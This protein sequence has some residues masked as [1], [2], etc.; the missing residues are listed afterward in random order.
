MNWFFSCIDH[1]IPLAL[2]PHGGAPDET[3]AQ[4]TVTAPGKTQPKYFILNRALGQNPPTFQDNLVFDTPLF[5]PI[6]GS[7]NFARKDRSREH[8]LMSPFSELERMKA[9]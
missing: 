6:M 8:K 2:G 5:F 9:S 1:P 4:G 7:H 3:Q